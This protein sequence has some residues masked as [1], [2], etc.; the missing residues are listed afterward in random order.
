MVITPRA[1]WSAARSNVGPR[2][3]SLTTTGL[4]PTGKMPRRPGT[5]RG[6]ADPT[7]SIDPSEVGHHFGKRREVLAPEPGARRRGEHLSR[8]RGRRERAARARR[9]RKGEIEGLRRQV[10]H[11]AGLPVV[12]RRAVRNAHWNRK[13]RAHR[14]TVTR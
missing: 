10:G 1:L 13:A 9:V 7:R 11:E 8:S 6:S 5:L 2:N 14:D 3:G 4:D 12:R